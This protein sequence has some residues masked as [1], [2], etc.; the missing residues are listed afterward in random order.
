M[1]YRHH[2]HAGN[3]ADVMKHVL[4]VRLVRALQRKDTGF[5][6]LDTHAGRGGYDLAAATTGDSRARKPE[7]PDGIGRLWNARDLP[8]MVAEYVGL[9][10]VFDRQ[11]GNLAEAV[12]FYPGSPWFSW[13]LARPQDRLVCCEKH[14]AE[15]AALRTAMGFG[16]R[17]SIEEIDGYAAMRGLLPPRERRA[18]ILID[19]PF[20]APDEFAQIAVALGGAL[21]RFPRGVFVIWYPLTRRAR[22]D[23][24]LGAVVALKPPPTLLVELA[25]A[26]ESAGLKM[27]G[28]G[29][30]VIN[31][32]W[33]FDGEARAVLGGLAA[34]LAQTPGGASVVDWL[35]AE[36]GVGDRNSP[37]AAGY[38]P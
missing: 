38:H 21:R 27:R 18:L 14:P 17:V 28:C 9:V 1:N 4:L 11:G 33:Q 6:Y 25:I 3:F 2:F 8:E 37:R 22:V 34:T 16:S 5:L 13:R 26:G 20:E 30:V 15:C 10:R 19:P 7:W 31:P 12:R 32:P 29:L 23:E 36:S 24:F 35:V